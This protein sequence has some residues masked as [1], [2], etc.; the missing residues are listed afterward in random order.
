LFKDQ[1]FALP[2]PKAVLLFGLVNDC[3]EV[4]E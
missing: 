2:P 4:V 3:E 1:T